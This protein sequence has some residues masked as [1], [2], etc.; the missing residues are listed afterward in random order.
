MDLIAWDREEGAAASSVLYSLD[1]KRSDNRVARYN[2]LFPPTKWRNGLPAYHASLGA[3]RC[4][5]PEE[6]PVWRAVPCGGREKPRRLAGWA[7][8]PRL[9]RRGGMKAV[10]CRG[11]PSLHCHAP[12]QD[13]VT[14]GRKKKFAF[15][16]FI[17]FDQF[18]LLKEFLSKQSSS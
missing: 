8:I 10:Q 4:L 11:E 13:T 14:A 17:V 15:P 1:G 6:E 16:P 2:P 18:S 3:P 7:R 9:A 5:P 12:S